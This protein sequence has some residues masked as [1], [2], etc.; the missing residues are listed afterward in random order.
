MEFGLDACGNATRARL[1]S[2]QAARADL[3]LVAAICRCPIVSRSLT[4]L[5]ATVNACASSLGNHQALTKGSQQVAKRTARSGDGNAAI[6]VA[7]R[8]GPVRCRPRIRTMHH[9]LWRKK[10]SSKTLRF[11]Y[12]SRAL[13]LRPLIQ[14][15][16]A[17]VPADIIRVAA[18]PTYT[19]PFIRES[20]IIL[21]VHLPSTPR[22]AWR[23]LRSPCSQSHNATNRA[24]P[25]HVSRRSA[26]TSDVSPPAHHGTHDHH[27]DVKAP[28]HHRLRLPGR[29]R[30]R[31]S[32]PSPRRKH[33]AAP[34]AILPRRPTRQLR[35]ETYPG[36][37]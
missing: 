11:A 25:G 1:G 7:L 6:L 30:H 15:P 18:L 9:E 27:H 2:C 35:E 37:V 22:P 13:W 19:P 29:R 12:Q 8:R 3:I 17:P 10:K 36:L 14:Q 21:A 16:P 20:V 31:R 34:H 4:G 5:T 24:R 28:R 33:A 26:P 32:A 23:R